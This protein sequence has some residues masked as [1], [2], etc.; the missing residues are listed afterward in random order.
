MKRGTPEH[1][2]LRL[3][4]RRL[5][6]PVYAA[7]GLVELLWHAT[8]KHA[9]DGAIGRFSDD[10]IAAALDWDRDPAELIEALVAARLLDRHDG[11]RLVVHGWPEHCDEYVHM[12]VAR[13]RSFFADGT[14]PRLTR[15]QGKER[16]RIHAW[17]AEHCAH[18]MRTTC[19]CC[20]T[21]CALP[22]PP[23]PPPPTDPSDL[24]ET[25][26]ADAPEP[27]ADAASPPSKPKKRGFR[28]CAPPHPDGDTFAA[29]FRE[30]LAVAHPGI[31]PPNPAAFEA[32]RKAARLMLDTD[33]RPLA[34]ARALARWLFTDP[35]GNAAFWRKNVLSVPKFR[36]KYDQLR[37]NQ[38]EVKASGA[39][40]QSTLLAWANEG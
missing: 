34:E 24:E 15:F 20:R 4:A 27:A 10:E 23:P 33:R 21:T 8:A 17:Y 16:D 25:E 1:P 18:G 31:K 39:H 37:A 6:L 14:E 9:Q 22:P 26:G 19:A 40:Q 2:K 32:W 38:T 28:D 12:A 35:G 11:H 13:S 7:V 29:D 5:R 36:E 30:S 3:V